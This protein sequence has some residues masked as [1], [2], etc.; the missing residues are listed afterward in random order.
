MDGPLT[1]GL[2]CECRHSGHGMDH[3]ARGVDADIR[4]KEG[5]GWALGRH[6][7]NA[8]WRRVSIRFLQTRG[9]E[10]AQSPRAKFI[11]TASMKRLKGFAWDAMQLASTHDPDLLLRI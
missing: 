9:G 10:V 8:L 3:C 4:P 7:S 6:R 11:E 1:D 2:R 5:R